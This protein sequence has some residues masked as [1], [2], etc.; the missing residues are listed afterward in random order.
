M[1]ELVRNGDPRL[2]Y[3]PLVYDSEWRD[4]GAESRDT[5][6]LVVAGRLRVRRQA[7]I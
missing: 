3:V 1:W 5:T 4:D 7:R 2:A 6:V